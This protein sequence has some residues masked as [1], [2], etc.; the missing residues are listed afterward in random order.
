MLSKAKHPTSEENES[1]FAALGFAEN[2]A[3]D[4]VDTP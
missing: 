4:F 3:R 1:F 2:R